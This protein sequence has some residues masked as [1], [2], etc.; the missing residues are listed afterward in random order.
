MSRLTPFSTSTCTRLSLREGREH[1]RG[2]AHA[3]RAAPALACAPPP[4]IG[5]GAVPPPS[6]ADATSEI[7]AELQRLA[8]NSATFG[9]RL[10]AAGGG[11]RD[12]TLELA[13]DLVRGARLDS[14]ATLSEQHEVDLSPAPLLVAEQRLPGAPRVDAHGL[15]RELSLDRLGVAAREPERGEQAERDGLAVGQVEVGRRLERVPEGVA[16]VEPAPR[17]AIVRV[18]QAERSLVRRRAAY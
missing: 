7:P 18:P 4:S 3:H 16:E 5:W 2:R 14:R 17:A 9:E 11:L 12:Q 6:A 1:R 10:V 8:N 15:R 13:A